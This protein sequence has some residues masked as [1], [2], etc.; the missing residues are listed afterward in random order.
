MVLPLW[1]LPDLLPKERIFPSDPVVAKPLPPFSD[2]DG[3]P[4]I[5]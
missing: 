3:Y 5:S 2:I 4:A 1:G